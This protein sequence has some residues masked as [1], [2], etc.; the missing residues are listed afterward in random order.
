M[1][2]TGKILFYNDSNGEG[3]II[4]QEKKKYKFSVNEWS[5]FESMPIAGLEVSFK[6]EED[7]AIEIEVVPQKE[8]KQ[9]KPIIPKTLPKQE[10]ENK[11]PEESSKIFQ[12]VTLPNNYTPLDKTKNIIKEK[13]ISVQA[14]DE[15]EEVVKAQR[16]KEEEL[17]IS[18][19]ELADLLTNS[20]QSISKLD[21]NIKQTMSISDTM[22]R[23]FHF[24]SESIN[25]RLGYKK[26]NGRLDYKLA[27]RFIW[28]T[29]NNLREIDFHIISIRIKSVSD[30]L[31]QMGRLQEDFERKVRYPTIAFEDIFL[32][33]QIEYRKTKIIAQKISE[34]LSSLKVKEHSLGVERKKFQ[35]QIEEEESLSQKQD[36]Q[37]KLKIISGTYVDIVHMIAK[38]QDEYTLQMEKLVKFEEEHKDLF[39]KEFT[40][41]AKRYKNFILDIVNAQAYLLDFLLWK[42]AKTS[43]AIL[44][45][46]KNLAIDVELNTKGYLK[47][48]LSTL[49]ESKTNEHTKE[50]FEL[51]KH[52][53]DIYKDYVL[54]LSDDVQDAMEFEQCIKGIVKNLG[55][56]AFIDELQALKWAM[57][58]SVKIIVITDT[59]QLS[60]SQKF[61]DSYHNNIFSKPEIVFLGHIPEKHSKNYSIRRVLPRNASARVVMQT[62]KE[63]IETLDTSV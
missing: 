28:T 44:N 52:L 57:T 33:S 39:N 16:Y 25:K 29:Y 63:V 60:S 59:L 13:K 50:L 12:E 27:K 7:K 31:K 6:I 42:E 23:Y 40:K 24:V 20:K 5:D 11:E 54:I 9:E 62:I 2:N 8:E 19:E 14:E 37:K 22:K 15:D 47:Y 41:E 56:K 49:D 34:K 18:E 46:F 30:D 36:L 32:S 17:T 43:K 61:L 48:Y 3:I 45:H 4:T 35:K 21:K 1:E 55:V 58:N 38:L 10:Q 26:V 53:Q 51:Y